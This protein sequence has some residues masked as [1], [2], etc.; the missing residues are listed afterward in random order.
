MGELLLVLHAL[1]IR[2]V[3]HVGKQRLQACWREQLPLDCIEDDAIELFAADARP[4]AGSALIHP[5]VANVVMI[6]PAL[7]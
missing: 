4:F 5:A 6:L 3:D 2:E 1:L 7:S